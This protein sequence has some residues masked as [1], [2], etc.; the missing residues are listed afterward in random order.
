MSGTRAMIALVAFVAV[1]FPTGHSIRPSGTDPAPQRTAVPVS[2]EF[3]LIM[4]GT[5]WACAAARKAVTCSAAA[6][7]RSRLVP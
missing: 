1:V 3:T 2:G 4:N 6:D 5:S 7:S